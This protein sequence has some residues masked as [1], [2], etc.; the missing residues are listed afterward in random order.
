MDGIAKITS[1]SHKPVARAGATSTPQHEQ[2]VKQSQKLVSQAFYGTLLKQ[3]RDSPFKSQLFNG[4]RGGE[5]FTAMLDQ[6]LADRMSHSASRGLVNSIVKR[7]ESAGKSRQEARDAGKAVRHAA[8]ER[9]GY[10]K[11]PARRPNV[12]ADFRA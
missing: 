6:H 7:M 12:S 2:L 4:G 11:R 9:S 8:L 3:M 5:A 1:T 10:L